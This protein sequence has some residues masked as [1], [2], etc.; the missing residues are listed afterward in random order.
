M[1]VGTQILLLLIAL[2]LMGFYTGRR[3][4]RA[5]IEEYHAFHAWRLAGSPQLSAA[6]PVSSTP[7]VQ[8]SSP[9]FDTTTIR[10]AGLAL[11]NP[12]GDL[13]AGLQYIKANYPNKRYAF[14]LG[15]KRYRDE[16]DCVTGS[17]VGDVNHILITGQSDVGKDN[18]A[19]NMLFSLALSYRPSQ[20]QI[21]ILDGK[22]GLSWH[23]WHTKEHTW[24]FARTSDDIKPAMTALTTERK[25]R[26]E[27]L[28]DVGAEKW[29][30]YQGGDLPL[31]VVY[32]S[33]LLLL[34]AAT[35]K[36]DLARWMSEEL[37]SARSSGIRYIVATQNATKFDTL[38]RSNISL[39]I[40]GYQTAADGDEP[41][42]TL[43]TKTLRELGTL[44]DGRIIAVPP[45]ELPAAPAG[46]GVFT[47]VQG[48][49]VNTVRSSYL[50]KEHQQWLL[51]KL[52][53]RPVQ[54][55]VE[56]STN[57]L[58]ERLHAGL[59][60]PMEE[61]HLSNILQ[62]QNEQKE[63]SVEHSTGFEARRTSED[64]R[65]KPT[66]EKFYVELPLTEDIV[67]YDEQ[68]RIIEHAQSV[69][70]RRRLSLD[71]YG[72]DGGQ[73]A[74]WVKAVCDAAGILPIQRAA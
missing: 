71:L 21:A 74:A 30:E 5:L 47:L 9:A 3:K 43:T 40:A 36:T 59:P 25:R 56:H 70:N 12:P 72:T 50:S 28:W 63:L 68:R 44:A 32:V 64:S 39:F 41:N 8:T 1:D 46:A 31:L 29:E 15:W 58:L 67:P 60:L 27:I 7:T 55:A 4:I 16:V 62:H 17:L 19:R 20:L 52:P 45:S 49:A 73:K 24:L 26:E 11:V 13:R 10:G 33:E 34:Q 22:S 57:Q 23:G 14:P 37:S 61:E 48:R 42:T 66:T 18:L 54:V 35:S 53:N 6:L 65:S 51:S 69:K 2:S 38:W